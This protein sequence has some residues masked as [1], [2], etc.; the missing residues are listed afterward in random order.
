MLYHY[1]I[2]FATMYTIM[3]IV[4]YMSV[5]PKRNGIDAVDLIAYDLHMMNRVRPL[6]Q[7]AR[8]EERLPR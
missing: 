1:N 2:I 8:V 7:L 3:F 6:D 4:W 5:N